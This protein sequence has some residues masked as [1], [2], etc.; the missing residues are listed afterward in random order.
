ML[1][2]EEIWFISFVY[3]KSCGSNPV[4][5]NMSGLWCDKRSQPWIKALRHLGC[6][7]A[8]AGTY[9]PCWSSSEVLP[10]HFLQFI[11]IGGKVDLIGFRP[12]RLAPGTTAGPLLN[13]GKAHVDNALC[14]RGTELT[15]HLEKSLW[16]FFPFLDD[17]VLSAA[18][19]AAPPQSAQ[20][21]AQAST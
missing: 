21:S 11:T 19:A 16:G 14:Q 18:A 9:L 15:S 1:S 10:G 4:P 2:A 20:H 7:C 8:A 12:T 17:L 13:D 3:D 6:V 5:A